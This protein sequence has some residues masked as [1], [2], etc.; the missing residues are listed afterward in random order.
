VL[1]CSCNGR[2]F[3]SDFDSEHSGFINGLPVFHSSLICSILDLLIFRPLAIKNLT[4]KSQSRKIIEDNED[5]EYATAEP[6]EDLY[7]LVGDGDQ[8]DMYDKRTFTNHKNIP[9]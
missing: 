7:S 2:G 4:L 5:S 3:A 9:Q 1:L 6:D 8:D